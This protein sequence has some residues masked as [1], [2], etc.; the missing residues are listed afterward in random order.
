MF[1]EYG[2]Q[3]ASDLDDA[4]L[5]TLRHFVYCSRAAHCVDDAEVGRIVESAQRSNR[6]HGITG[7][8]VYGGGVF[9]QW[10][11]GPPAQIQNL[12]ANLHSDPRHYDIVSLSQSEEKR[13]RLYPNW[14]MERVET[15]DIRVVLKDAL[16]SV[17]DENSAAAIKRIL[18]NFGSAP[19][20]PSG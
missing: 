11:E 1:D 13:E 18:D 12:I 9:F 7:V 14:E 15:E 20:L 6:A 3:R 5:P 2:L 17:E 8:L 19:L 10:I 4:P 16:E